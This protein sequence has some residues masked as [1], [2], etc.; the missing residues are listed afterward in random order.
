MKNELENDKSYLSD[1]VSFRDY[2]LKSFLSLC[3][4][5]SLFPLIRAAD[6]TNKLSVKDVL[7]KFPK[8]YKIPEKTGKH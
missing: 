8:A 2:F 5:Y 1:D 4:Y 6:L 3:L 7:M